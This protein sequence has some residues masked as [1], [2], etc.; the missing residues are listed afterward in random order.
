[1][2][3]LF[4][5]FFGGGCL[6]TSSSELSMEELRCR[7]FGDEEG[8]VVATGGGDGQMGGASNGSGGGVPSLDVV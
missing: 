3:F 1:M 6:G 2:V 5:L 4:S 7:F 8:E